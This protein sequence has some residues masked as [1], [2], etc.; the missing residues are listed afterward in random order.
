MNQKTIEDFRNI[1]AGETVL[2]VGNGE[3]LNLTPP[4][5]FHLPSIGMNTIHKYQGWRPTYYTGVDNRLMREFGKEV[6]EKYSDI[7][8]FVP[9]DLKE[10][11]GNNFVHFYHLPKDLKDGWKPDTLKDGITYHSSMHVA[12]QLAYWMGFKTLLMIGVSHKPDDGQPHFWGRDEGM[13]KQAPLKDF[14]MGYEVLTK[15]MRERGV[16]VIN[17]SVETYVPNEVLPRG[18]WKEWL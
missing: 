8:K 2:L 5:L 4:E 18:N 6:S 17:I 14:L 1:H 12:M 15:G 10:W 11:N 16:A 7:P 3:N 9:M 13:P